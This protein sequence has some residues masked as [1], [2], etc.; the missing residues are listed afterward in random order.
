MK[1]Y[2]NRIYSI[3]RKDIKTE[4]LEK[5]HENVKSALATK[6]LYYPR[7]MTAM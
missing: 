7:S 1:E 6:N 5:K 4:D 3:N 2:Q